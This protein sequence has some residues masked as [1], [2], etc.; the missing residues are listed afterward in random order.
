MKDT[1]KVIIWGF[2]QVGRS[3]LQIIN[4]RKSLELVGV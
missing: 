1:Y 3:A 2:G 4:A